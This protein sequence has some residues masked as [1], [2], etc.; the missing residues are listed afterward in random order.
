M[1]KRTQ[2]AF[3]IFTHFKKLRLFRK[4]D[5]DLKEP[6]PSLTGNKEPV[7]LRIVGDAV[8]HVIWVEGL[9]A[10][11]S[12]EVYP[13]LNLT[14]LCVD[15]GYSVFLPNVSVD[16]AVYEFKFIKVSYFP[17]SVMHLNISDC[18]KGYWV[19]KAERC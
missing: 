9:R 5:S 14:C 11:E 15:N 12:S 17:L 8:Q 18:L 19:K 13:S 3:M 10:I 4:G 16:V 7:F 1:P 6:G 2:L